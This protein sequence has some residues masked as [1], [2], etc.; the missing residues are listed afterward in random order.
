M[1]ISQR[2][3]PFRAQKCFYTIPVMANSCFSSLRLLNGVGLGSLRIG[4]LGILLFCLR[5]LALLLGLSLTLLALDLGLLCGGLLL[6]LLASCLLLTL[7]LVVVALDDGSSD[8]ADVLLLRDV[9]C[10]CSVL[11]VF[12]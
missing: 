10:L 4:H 2:P 9:L 1:V 5:S 8:R 7:D 12:V 3:V 6:V 11:A